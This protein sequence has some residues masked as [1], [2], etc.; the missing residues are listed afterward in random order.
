MRDALTQLRD[1]TAE[2]RTQNQIL[3]QNSQLAVAKAHE[4][5]VWRRACLLC[6]G[7]EGR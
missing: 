1:E 4:L 3:M 6:R 2:L 5:Q 7:G